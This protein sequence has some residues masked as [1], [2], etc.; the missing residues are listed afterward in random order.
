MANF[1]IYSPRKTGYIHQGVRYSTHPAAVHRVDAVA[2]ETAEAA[3]KRR[4]EGKL[5]PAEEDS[6]RELTDR[7]KKA[8]IEPALHILEGSLE[9]ADLEQEINEKR[10]YLADLDNL[11][12]ETKA[13]IAGAAADL[14][15]ARVRA[16]D[17]EKQAAQVEDQRAAA[18]RELKA[19]EQEIASIKDLEAKLKKAESELRKLRRDKET[20]G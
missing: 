19:L 6:V 18:E 10:T 1:M 13:K 17:A 9:S 7:A 15:A 12:A 20:Q 14:D 8:G 5:T 11:V 3:L 2:G 4:K 16:L